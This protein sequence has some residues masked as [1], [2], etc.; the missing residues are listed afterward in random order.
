MGPI[1][2]AMAVLILAVVGLGCAHQGRSGAGLNPLGVSDMKA[3]MRDL[4]SGHNFWIRNVV[5][6]HT[7][8]NRKALD[9]AE[10]A[11]TANAK[12]IANVFTPFYG[13]AA[14][15]QLFA[16]LVKHYGAI[17]AYSEATVAGS[18]SLQDAAL[19]D[20]ASNTDEIAAFLSGANRYLPKATVQGLFAA[21]GAHHVE[22]IN[23]L[24]AE[25]YGHEAETWQAMQ[26]H[27]YA[28]ADTLTTALEKQFPAKFPSVHIQ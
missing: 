26:Q 8:N 28:I 9:F 27:V 7:T 25:D 6:D 19:A 23:E 15:E 10:K 20:Y 18:K 21:H 12:Q 2:R 24:Q 5:L 11:V 1:H 13:E 4:W 16:L 14:T 17:K 3:V 22:L